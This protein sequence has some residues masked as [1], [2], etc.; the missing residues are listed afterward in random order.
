M[1]IIL[2]SYRQ[3]HGLPEGEEE[4]IQVEF[5]PEVEIDVPGKEHYVNIKMGNKIARVKVDELKKVVEAST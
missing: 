2:I 3:R 4:V 1:K 5:C